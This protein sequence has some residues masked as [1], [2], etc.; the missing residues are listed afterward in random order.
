VVAPQSTDR[1]TAKLFFKPRRATR[2]RVPDVPGFPATTLTIESSLGRLT[3][4]S[5]GEGPTILF[6]HGW[7]GFTGQFTPIL[8]R[9]VEAGFR[10]VAFDMPAHGQS[11]G[12]HVSAVDMAQAIREV[13]DD[14][15]P[16]VGKERLAPYAIVAHSLGGA[17]ASLALFEGLGAERV[18]LLAPVADPIIFA[19]RAASFLSLSPERTEG[20][21]QSIQA[22]VGRTFEELDIRRKATR[23]TA[24]ALIFHDTG[25]LDVP[26]DHGR[27]IAAAWPGAEFV[28]LEGLGHSKLL[29][30]PA[31]VDR[32]VR[33][34]T[35]ERRLRAV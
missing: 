9:V 34:L 19:K 2:I 20:M 32:A 5:W 10:A 3:A 27:D 23:L 33:F 15:M 21:L 25:D 8:Q 22:L 29:K 7:E 13:A 24:K 1:L 28:P 12:T 17:A 6:A 26:F 16:F 35:A 18:V 31:V 4:W 11:E 14:V 30:D